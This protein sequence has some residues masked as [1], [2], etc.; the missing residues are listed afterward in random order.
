[1]TTY[2]Y[3]IFTAGQVIVCPSVCMTSRK[4][5]LP[6]LHKYWNVTVHVNL[7][8]E[9]PATTSLRWENPS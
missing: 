2:L 8:Y 5:F 7:Y 4:L 3:K 1:M 9:Q 6:A